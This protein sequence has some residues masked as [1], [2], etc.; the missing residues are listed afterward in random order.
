[1]GVKNKVLSFASPADLGASEVRP[2]APLKE[3]SLMPS[4]LET[5]D[6]ALYEW[7]DQE[8]NISTKTNKGFKKVPIIWAGS[9]RSHQIKQDQDLRDRTGTLKL[10]IIS[11]SRESVVKDSNFKGI[12]W[13]H[14][15]NKNDAKGGAITV[16]RR[17]GQKKTA[18]FK[19]AFSYR[20]FKDNNFP[21]DKNLM[22]NINIRTQ[23][24]QQ[25]NE[26]LNPFVTKT[27]QIDNF[28]IR[29][30]GHKFEGF[31][32]GNFGLSNN[33]TSMANN[34]RTYETTIQAK[35]LGYLLGSGVNEERPKIT[36][37]ENAVTV[38]Q[39]RERQMLDDE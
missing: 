2:D 22:Y 26:I 30:D 34:E 21:T 20:E 32:Q 36:I 16:A 25:A 19:N 39:S 38:V 35:I 3:V 33:V 37:R 7:L 5:I 24:Q 14:I 11:V 27:G 15:P 4:T 1:M 31:I 29:Q 8:L 28:F 23:Y 6:M 12:A 17:I 10:P 13:A 9:E 18:N